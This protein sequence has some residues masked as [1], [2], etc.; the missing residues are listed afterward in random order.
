MDRFLEICK[1]PKWIKK[2]I[3][4]LNR[5]IT[6]KE[7]ESV[8]KTLEQSPGSNGLIDEFYQTFI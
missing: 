3:E 4:N 8:F 7:I 5:F 2:V 1:W 6:P